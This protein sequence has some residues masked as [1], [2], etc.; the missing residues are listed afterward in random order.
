MLL[1]DG[2]NTESWD[3]A[4]NKKITSVSAIDARTALACSNIKAAGIKLYTVRVIEGNAALLQSCATNPSM[5]FNVQSAA[6]LTA[7]FTSISKSLANLR[8]A[9]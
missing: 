2:D 1:T 3:N 7:V 9:K 5:Y 4:N 6:S 8:I